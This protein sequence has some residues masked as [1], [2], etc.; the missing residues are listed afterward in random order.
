MHKKSP[1]GDFLCLLCD[2]WEKAHKASTLDSDRELALIL[3]CSVGAS[4]SE[5]SSTRG[6]ES[7]EEL[8]IFVVNMLDIV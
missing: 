1:F 7:L 5:H 4:A 6:K 3:G 2:I 8:Y